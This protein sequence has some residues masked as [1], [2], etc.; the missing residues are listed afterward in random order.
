MTDKIIR[1]PDVRRVL[2]CGRGARAWFRLRGLDFED[3]CSNGI[4][5]HDLEKIDCK[6]AEQVVKGARE[7]YGW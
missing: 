7:Y 1:M 2:M 4:A 5:L 6:M 3:F